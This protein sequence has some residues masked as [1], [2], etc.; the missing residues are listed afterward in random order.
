MISAG[1]AIINNSPTPYR[2]DLHLR[3]AREMHNAV[4]WSVFTHEVSNSPWKLEIPAE[5]RPVYFG[6]GKRSLE[7]DSLVSQPGEWRKAGIIIRWLEQHAIEAVVLGGYNDIGRLRI[8]WWCNRHGLP[9][10]LF[11]DSNIHCDSAARGWKHWIKRLLLPRILRRTSG[12]LCCGSYGEEFFRHYG[13][14]TSNIFRFPYEPDY[15]RLMETKSALIESVGRKY[16]LHESRRYLMYSGRLVPEKRV[17]LLFVAFDRIATLRPEWDLLIVG[18]GVERGALSALITERIAAR[19]IWTGF[20]NQPDTMRALYAS[21]RVLVLPS[22][23]EPW[24]VVVSEA[25]VRIPVVASSVV[26]AAADLIRDG[27]NG[28]IFDVGDA[29][30]LTECLLHVTDPINLDAMTKAAPSHFAQWHDR[31]D[32]VKGLRAALQSVAVLSAS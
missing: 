7:S 15:V 10:F 11:G 30:S 31:S 21:A 8:L 12:V 5:I 29:D 23:Y 9:C 25:A 6:T 18:D 1:I 3:L 24:G 20:V 4:I 27:I 14:V 26:G 32:P 17:D 28:R 2:I 16:G 22:D 19:V 13:V